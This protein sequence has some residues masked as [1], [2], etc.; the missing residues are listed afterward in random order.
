MVE[1]FALT[2]NPVA[3][4]VSPLHLNSTTSQSRLTSAATVQGFKAQTALVGRSLSPGEG[5]GVRAG[6]VGEMGTSN[7]ELR[8]IASGHPTPN[9]E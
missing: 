7:I 9:L 5:A 2:M 6:M 8:C 3:A 4:D 1:T